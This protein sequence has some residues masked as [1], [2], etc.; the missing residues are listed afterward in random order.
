MKNGFE[1]ELN[2]IIKKIDEHEE[3]IASHIEEIKKLNKQRKNYE[4]C[5]RL[6]ESNE[7]T[8]R[9]RRS[10][11]GDK[12]LS[13]PALLET[14]GQKQSKALKYTELASLVKESGYRSHSR[15]FSNMVYQA[16]EK[17][18]EKKRFSKEK[19]TRM[20]TY[21]GKDDSEG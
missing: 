12:G 19:K 5:I 14:I 3:E 2:N 18:V 1:V 13:L 20:Y 16:L 4:K 17:L 10:S 15:N 11:K 21:I 9:G 6:L 8:P 7:E